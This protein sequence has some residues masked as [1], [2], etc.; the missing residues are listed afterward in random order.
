MAERTTSPLL[1]AW[2]LRFRGER[3]SA[4]ARSPAIGHTGAP[5]HLSCDGRSTAGVGSA[6]AVGLQVVHLARDDTVEGTDCLRP[7]RAQ[8]AQC[9]RDSDGSAALECATPGRA[10]LRL[11]GACDVCR[12]DGMGHAMFQ[13]VASKSFGAVVSTDSAD[14][15]SKR[16]FFVCKHGPPPRLHRTRL[17]V[18]T[19]ATQNRPVL[20]RQTTV[21]LRSLRLCPSSSSALG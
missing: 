2:Q 16:H 14:P 21:D 1:T 12:T 15:R 4:S 8:N 18:A 9:I 19:L 5:E 20:S 11:C 7:H 10:A 17:P 6:S 3:D 13:L